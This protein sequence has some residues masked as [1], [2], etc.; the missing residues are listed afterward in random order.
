MEKRTSIALG[1]S[2]AEDGAASHQQLRSC[3]DD[4]RDGLVSD[5]AIDLY[6]IGQTHGCAHLFQLANLGQGI[7]DEALPAESRIDTHDQHVVQHG[8]DGNQEVYR[9]GRVE[10]HAG[11]HAVLGDEPDRPVQVPAR[12]VVHPDPV[13]AGLRKSGDKVV[14]ALDHQVTVERQAGALTQRVDYRGPEGDVGHEVAVHYVDVNGR[15]TAALGSRNFVSQAREIGGEDGRQKLDHDGVSVSGASRV[16]R[17]VETR[18]Q[19]A[20]L[21]WSG[22]CTLTLGMN[23]PAPPE[24]PC[25][26]SRMQ[27]P[28]LRLRAQIWSL[29]RARISTL[30]VAGAILLAGC[31]SPGTP[32]PPSLKL[33]TPPVDL[34]ASRSGDTV[35]LHWTMPR[36]A[37]DRV[38]LSGDQ[39]VVICRGPGPLLTPCSPVGG[40]LLLP[41]T[42]AGFLDPLPP[43]LLLGPPRLLTYTVLV[44]NHRGR[45]AGPS[46]PAYSAAG[47]P[48]PPIEALHAEAH[49]EGIV[50]SWKPAG[51]TTPPKGAAQAVGHAECLLR[52]HRTRIPAA[53]EQAEPT[54]EETRAGVPQPVEQ[55]LVVPEAST[56]THAGTL[57]EGWTLD[58][59]I[60]RDA[61]LNH[62][63]RYTV[64][65]VAQVTLDGHE[66]EVKGAVSAPSTV[67]ARDLFPPHIPE[68]LVAV[69]DSEGGAID[70][71]W[72]A[73]LDTDLAGYRVY[74][75]VAGSGSPPERVSGAGLVPNAD[76]RDSSAQTGVRYA[77]SVSAVDTSGNESA[78][79]AEVEEVLVRAGKPGR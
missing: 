28:P 39:R 68:G 35:T 75:R 41:G 12:L 47:A 23:I 21:P 1:V 50:L 67:S 48:P 74:R 26:R 34:S 59:A 8:Q 2:F 14:R 30:A 36:R 38:P 76:W 54:G 62:T 7:R 10:N 37:T 60:D 4:Q 44:E 16:V 45:G 29:R 51:R 61:A 55:T 17:V 31:G 70:L 46:N 24:L 22:S 43:E 13:R 27:T 6:L 32:Q 69:A 56:P 73:D 25:P 57:A 53:R 64:E 33:P 20:R 3:F 9:G 5:P 66:V 65:R 42:D 19:G 79:S 72:T 58:H 78:R 11:L 18:S 49:P 77:Y 63:Y 15:A 71:S 40:L 52:L